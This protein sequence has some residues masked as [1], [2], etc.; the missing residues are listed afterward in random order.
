MFQELHQLAVEG[1]CKLLLAMAVEGENL[2]VTVTPLPSEKD[3]SAGLSQPLKLVGTPAELDAQFPSILASFSTSRKT[4]Q[5]SLAD[6]QA[7]MD[8]AAKDASKK[9]VETVANGGKK[10]ATPAASAPAA[11]PAATSTAPAPATANAGEV[12]LF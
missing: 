1:K 4:L 9:A 3:A 7:V 12:A 11:E 8:A 2:A 5:E 6:A 10:P